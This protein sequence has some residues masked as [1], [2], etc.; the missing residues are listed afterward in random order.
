MK[1]II[2][3]TVI[4]LLTSLPSLAARGEFIGGYYEM[5][6]PASMDALLKP[7]N[8]ICDENK[9]FDITT[10]WRPALEYGSKIYWV[11]YY[12]VSK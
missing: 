5:R 7:L 12:C 11:E 2:G 4:S 8:K 3:A 10:G 6:D 1:K 9:H